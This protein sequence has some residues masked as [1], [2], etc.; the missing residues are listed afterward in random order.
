MSLYFAYGSNLNLDQMQRRC[1]AAVPLDKLYLPDARLVFRG[2]ADVVLEP[3]AECPGGLWR[4]TPACERAL[5]RYEGY[6]SDGSG[7]YRKI[8]ITL[9]GLPDGETQIMLY[10]MRSTGIMPPAHHYYN[11]IEDGYA[12]FGLETNA[13]LAALKNAHDA[14]HLTHVERKRVRRNGRPTVKAR[15][16]PKPAK[17]AKKKR[18]K[19]E[20]VDVGLALQVFVRAG[21]RPAAPVK[22]VASKLGD[23]K[24]ERRAMGYRT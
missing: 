4:I 5:D 18:K 8:Y 23:W 1:P 14:M 6:R 11:V 13:L 12:D 24:A 3:G 19:A 9:P 7:M 2:V 15:P 16:V 20:A 22:K 17:V 21:A 10:V